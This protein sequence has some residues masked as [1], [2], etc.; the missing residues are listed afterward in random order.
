LNCFNTRKG[1]KEGSDQLC[2]EGKIEGSIKKCGRKEKKK[3]W[4][5]MCNKNVLMAKGTKREIFSP[6]E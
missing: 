1:S 4:H 2:K 5:R 3:G 6:T